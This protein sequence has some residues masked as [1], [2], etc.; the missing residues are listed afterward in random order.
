MKRAVLVLA[1]AGCTPL[2][3]MKPDASLATIPEISAS[4]SARVE[5]D[6]AI[7]RWWKHFGDASLGRLMDEALARNA[8]LESALGRVREAQASLDAVRAAQMPTLDANARSSRDQRSNVSAMPIPPGVGRQ[9]SSHKLSFDAGYEADLWGRLSSSTKAARQ[10]LLATEWARAAVEWGVTASVAETYFQL[11]AIDRQIAISEAMRA[12]RARNVELRNREN[13]AGVG[14]EFDLRR[15]EAELTSTQATLAGLQRQRSSLERTLALL[16]G[17][18]PQ[19]IASLPLERQ[20]LDE[21]RAFTPVLPQ[22]AA[23]Q[24]LVRRPDIRQAEAQLAAANAS[25]EAARAA[26]FPA[27]RLS[28]SVGSDARSMSDL[29]TGP[30]AIWS[31]AASLSQPIFDGGR[32]KAQVRQEEARGQR[33]LAEY[34]KAVTTAVADVRDAYLALELERQAWASQ[35]ARA[36]ALERAMSLARLGYDEGA[37][38]FLDYLDAERN[39]YQAQLDQVSAYRDG[40]IGQVAAFKALGGG[41]TQGST[42]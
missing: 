16:T 7:D 40:L 42:L 22:G 12:G 5:Q 34:R 32:L 10:Q 18:T 41:H 8:D 24:L 35:K 1:L 31:V 36:A 38:G 4:Q 33:A 26:T 27:L 21:G 23:A 14:T 37:L 20:A 9:T 2:V 19:Q 25:I 3:Q 6:L 30:A 29:F 39:W 28:G 13:A 17:R 11:A 15:A